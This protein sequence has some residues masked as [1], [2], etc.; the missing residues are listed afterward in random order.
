MLPD[1][2]MYEWEYS[3]FQ[4]DVHILIEGT[5]EASI[6]Y[7][8]TEA[9]TELGKIEEAMKKPSFDDEYH[10]H[11]V[12]EHVDVLVT[13]SGQERFLRNMAL[14]ALASRFAHALREMARTAELFSK[15]KE[16]RYDGKNEFE[17][18]WAEYFERFGVDVKNS[19]RIAFVKS[20]VDVRNQIVHAGGEANIWKPLD[21]IDWN[22]TGE[23]GY[24][25]TD[26]S[27]QYPEYVSG[28]GMSAEVSVS[29]ELLDKNIKG[30]IELVAWLAGELRSR[31]L[32]SKQP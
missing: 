26:F 19:G 7:L 3:Q 25:N 21:R 31:E 10:E 29:Q 14:V 23:E 2:D 8:D 13:N 9:R 6:R 28:T 15:R 27:K 30:S 32:A 24:L 11:L 22:I 17:R 20:M 18:L 5:L 1:V 4:W 16:G 12:D